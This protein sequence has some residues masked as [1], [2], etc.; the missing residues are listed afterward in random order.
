MDFNFIFSTNYKLLK[1]SSY[2][3]FNIEPLKI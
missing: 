1:I 2:I 3:H